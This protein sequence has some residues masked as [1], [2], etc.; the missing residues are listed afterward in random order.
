MKRKIGEILVANG[1]VSAGD[2]D[3]ALADQS[4]GEPSRLGDLLVATGKISSSQLARGLAEQ[5]ELPFVE[6]PH[7]PQAVLDLVPLELQRQYRF[8]PLKSDG[9]E[10]SIAM[11]DLAN[12]E[13]VALLEQ[14]WTRVHVHVAGGDEIDALHATLSGIFR[15][16]IADHLPSIAPAISPLGSADDLFGSLDLTETAATE[17]NGAVS[18]ANA[19]A[20]G[21][22][23]IAPISTPDSPRP[24]PAPP[25]AED[26][27][28]DLDLQSART[29]IP[30]QAPEAIAAPTNGASSK[31]EVDSEPPLIGEEESSVTT[32][33]PIK[34]PWGDDVGE[35]IETLEPIESN[36]DVISAVIEGVT[37]SE[38]ALAAAAAANSGESSGPII[39][40]KEGTGPLLDL[41]TVDGGTGPVVDTPFFRDANVDPSG[42]RPVPDRPFGSGPSSIGAIAIPPPMPTVPHHPPVDVPS[43]PPPESSP[44]SA[45]PLPDW[46][47]TEGAGFRSPVAPPVPTPGAWTGALDHLAPSKLVLGLT[48]AL[49]ARGLVTEEEILAALGQKK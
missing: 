28:G 14:Q 40:I 11:A 45:E 20:P 9:T 42:V 31:I 43:A 39:G 26:L 27:F 15:S 6:L 49:L 29:G 25:R 19:V 10:L 41:I 32:L 33:E 2:V 35:P 16:P 17:G 47:K 1:A 21:V 8:V 44:S 13:V 36:S 18:P 34:A 48:R 12:V 7:L 30:V 37:A 46:L 24:A 5:Y 38:P 3:G 22:P 23:F 4:A